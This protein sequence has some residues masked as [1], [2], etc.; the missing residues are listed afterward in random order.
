MR[1]PD[2]WEVGELSIAICDPVSHHTPTLTIKTVDDGGGVYLN[3]DVDAGTLG[4]SL[5]VEDLE[6]IAALG[7]HLAELHDRMNSEAPTPGLIHP[8][9]AITPTAAGG[10]KA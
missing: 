10:P 8:A 6:R 7:R 2:G 1:L 5:N 9:A 3:L 4:V